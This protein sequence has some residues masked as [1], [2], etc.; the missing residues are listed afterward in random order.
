MDSTVFQNVTL[1]VTLSR[2]EIHYLRTLLTAMERHK[3]EMET[4]GKTDVNVLSTSYAALRNLVAQI[5][6]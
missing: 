5:N 4:I 1:T 2:A 3:S 6:V